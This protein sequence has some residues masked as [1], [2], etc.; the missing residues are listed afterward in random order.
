M[1][2]NRA[3]NQ[4]R[5]TLHLCSSRS[6]SGSAESMVDKARNNVADKRRSYRKRILTRR[7]ETKCGSA[8]VYVG[9]VRGWSEK[10]AVAHRRKHETE[11]KGNSPAN[12]GSSPFGDERANSAAEEV[13][14]PA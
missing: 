4:N 9:F 3:D 6:S 11:R 7:S 12:T 5:R 14:E 10:L 1:F 8:L 13:N 2:S